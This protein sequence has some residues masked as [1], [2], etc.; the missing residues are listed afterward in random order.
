MNVEET[1]NKNYGEQLVEVEMIEGSPFTVVKAP[2]ET[3][4]GYFIGLGKYKLATGFESAEAAKKYISEQKVDWEF[5]SQIMTVILTEF[6]N[7]KN[8][9]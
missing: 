5:L 9:K 8:N 7:L 3:G 6:E 1:D 4:E 2:A